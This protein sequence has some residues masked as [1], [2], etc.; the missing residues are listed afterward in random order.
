MDDDDEEAALMMPEQQQLMDTGMPMHG[1]LGYS[2][3]GADSL[4]KNVSPACIKVTCL[5]TRWWFG[6]SR[7]AVAD[8]RWN[9]PA[10]RSGVLHGACQHDV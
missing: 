9:S 3:V 6:S 8:G 2:M 10:R 1:D 4:T 5:T 7:P